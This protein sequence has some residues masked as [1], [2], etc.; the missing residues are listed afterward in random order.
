MTIENKIKLTFFPTALKGCRGIAITLGVRM[1][2]RAVGKDCPA[3]ISETV[4]CGKLILGRDTGE[5][6]KVCNVMVTLI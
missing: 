1:G 3:C 2:G 6:V 5:G 4:R